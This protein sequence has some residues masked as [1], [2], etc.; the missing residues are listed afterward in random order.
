ML[1]NPFGLMAEAVRVLRGNLDFMGVD[2]DVRS[3]LVSS[4]VQGEGKSMTA[5]NLAVS[6][7]LAGKRVVL[8]DADLRRPRIHTYLG[9]QNS[10][11]L[12]SVVARRAELSDALVSITLDKA[13]GTGDGLAAPDVRVREGALR[14]FSVGG[15]DGGDERTADAVSGRDAGTAGWSTGADDNPVLRVLPSGPLPPNPGEM[16]ASRRFSELIDELADDADLVLVD[17]PALLSVGDTA[18]MAAH[19]DGLVFVVNTA[20]VRRPMLERVARPARQ[21]ALPQAR[22]RP[23]LEQTCAR[24]VLRVSLSPRLRSQGGAHHYVG[25]KRRGEPMQRRRGRAA[26]DTPP[27]AAEELGEG[28]RMSATKPKPDLPSISLVVPW[29]GPL[30][31]WFDIWLVTCG[32][33]PTIDWLLFTDEPLEGRPVPANVH[34]HEISLAGLRRRFNEMLGMEVNLSHPYLLCNLKLA[35]GFL[36]AKELAGYELW[37][38]CDADVV[39]GDLRRFF[40]AELLRAYPKLQQNA[41]LT[42]YQN[43]PETV[44]LFRQP[45]P[46][47]HKDYRVV[48]REDHVVNF[49]RVVRSARA[50]LSGRPRPVPG[51]ALRRCRPEFGRPARHRLAQLRAPALLLGGRT[52][53]SRVH[54]RSRRRSRRRRLAADA[55]RRVRLSAPAEASHERARLRPVR[56]ARFLHHPPR[57]RA[58]GQGGPLPRRLPPVQPARPAAGRRWRHGRRAAPCASPRAQPPAAATV[59]R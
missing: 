1:V 45:H 53:V 43:T 25:L 27:C 24:A 4:S 51:G 41:H 20:Q 22:S 5:C 8:V 23:H 26:P 48:F 44:E 14:V 56:R 7:A 47:P 16:V 49:C 36:F 46:D 34:V 28:A 59:A 9:V 50:R 33:N 19:V 3:L 54:R 38:Y 29:F 55:T 39:W 30:P 2:G 11:G 13:V 21:A 15:R 35:Y 18:A 6:M 40:P 12:S 42:L 57:L 58:E 31:V 32:A 52:P 10:V 37:G 17:T